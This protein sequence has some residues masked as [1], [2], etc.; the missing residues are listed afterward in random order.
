MSSSAT[1]GGRDPNR[2]FSL[3]RSTAASTAARNSP[4]RPG[5]WPSY[6]R[7]ASANSAS[8]SSLIR[9]GS[10]NACR[11]RFGFGRELQ[12]TVC[13]GH[14]PNGRAPH[15]ARS[16]PPML[17]RH[18]DRARHPSWQAT[19]QPV[20]PGQTGPISRRLPGVFHLPYSR[21]A[22]YLDERR[23]TR[24]CSCRAPVVF[25]STAALA[26]FARQRLLPSGG[27]PQWC[28]IAVSALAA[29]RR[30]VGRRKG[31]R[32]DPTRRHPLASSVSC[33]VLVDDGIRG[34]ESFCLADRGHG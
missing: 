34:I 4:P 14:R 19:P 3:I 1:P 7:A 6:Q 8:A 27:G 12:A 11:G 33:R 21:S 30:S 13:R 23:P 16:R 31:H 5:R 2:G 20:L 15:A 17:S 29:E 32:C 10:F 22:G 25:R 24:R 18:P 26:R 28:K 9:S